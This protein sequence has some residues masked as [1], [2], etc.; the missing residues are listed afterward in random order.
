MMAQVSGLRI[1]INS[2]A[3]RALLQSAEVASE[4]ERRGNAIVEA[5]GGAPD[6]EVQSTKNRDRAVAFV[7]TASSKGKKAEAEDRVLTRAI[8]AGR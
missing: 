8:D 5:A 7:R 4:L 6:F 2:D 1:K 3:V